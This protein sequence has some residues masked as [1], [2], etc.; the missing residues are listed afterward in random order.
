MVRRLVEQQQS[1]AR[2][3]QLRQRDAHLPAARERLARLVEVVWRES[4][5]AQD[6]RDLQ[7][8]AVALETPE[9]LLQFAVPREHRRVLGFGDRVVAKPLF[10]R[11]ESPPAC[12]AA[13]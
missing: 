8:D 5:P 12:R 13:A 11:A 9:V 1:G 2:E 7:V 10:E 4:Q 3:Q 6:G